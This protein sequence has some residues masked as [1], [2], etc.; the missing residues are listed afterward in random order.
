M[1]E[2]TNFDK[3]EYFEAK[4]II[5]DRMMVAKEFEKLVKKLKRKKE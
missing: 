4:N 1:T 2:Q 3:K 5:K